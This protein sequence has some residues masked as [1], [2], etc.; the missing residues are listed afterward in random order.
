MVCCPLLTSGALLPSSLQFSLK[1][2]QWTNIL[3]EMSKQD[4][5]KTFFI[6]V[7]SVLSSTFFTI[8]GITK[9]KFMSKINVQ[10]TVINCCL[11][12]YVVAPLLLW[13]VRPS[14]NPVTPVLKL[15]LTW[16]LCFLF[17]YSAFICIWEGRKLAL[18]TQLPVDGAFFE[19]PRSCHSLFNILILWLL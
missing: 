18:C 19:K 4:T 14:S 15:Y 3:C 5:G 13:H 1:T 17:V 2:E 12:D 10:H 16:L 8:L 9:G 6:P 7:L 11:S